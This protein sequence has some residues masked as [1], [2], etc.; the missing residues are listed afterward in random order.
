M[1]SRSWVDAITVNAKDKTSIWPFAELSV[2][3]GKF[4]LPGFGRSSIA[5]IS[6]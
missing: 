6:S 3:G 1:I 5:V 4:A 2:T